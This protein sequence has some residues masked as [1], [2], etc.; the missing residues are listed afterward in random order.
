MQLVQP[1][2]FAFVEFFFHNCPPLDGPGATSSFP[3]IGSRRYGNKAQLLAAAT[4]QTSWPLQ[5]SR[6][7]GTL[8]DAP[9]PPRTSFQSAVIF[10]TLS[11]FFFFCSQDP[12]LDTWD[13]RNRKTA[14]RTQVKTETNWSRISFR[15][16][17]G[18]PTNNS[19]ARVST[20]TK[21]PVSCRADQ[22]ALLHATI[23]RIFFSAI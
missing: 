11:T 20:P 5:R 9:W 22:T 14:L 18:I 10:T 17:E 1:P 21:H 23:A 13:M 4:L 8:H 19:V 16:F 15:V 2:R 3:C 6:S 12:F 7:T